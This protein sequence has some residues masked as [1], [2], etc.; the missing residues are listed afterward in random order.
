V[1]NTARR[2]ERYLGRGIGSALLDHFLSWARERRFAG[3][4]A[5]ATADE[6]AVMEFLGGFPVGVYQARGFTIICRWVDYDP[7]RALRERQFTS[8]GN[9]DSSTVA[10]CVLRLR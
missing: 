10:C 8:D 3:V 6:R 5:K 1:D 4:I 2:D 7:Q 9:R